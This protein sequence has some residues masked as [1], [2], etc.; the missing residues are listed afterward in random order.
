MKCN[1]AVVAGFIGASGKNT[2]H[3][4]VEDWILLCT[5]DGETLNKKELYPAHKSLEVWCRRVIGQSK[6]MDQQQANIFEST[7]HFECQ[8]KSV[9]DFSGVFNLL[10]KF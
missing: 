8:A 5:Y 6:K 4:Q 10:G 3:L 9:K 7:A 1:P 2:G